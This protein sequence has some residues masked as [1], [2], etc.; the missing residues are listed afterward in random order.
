MSHLHRIKI[1]CEGLELLWRSQPPVMH[2]EHF[3]ASGWGANQHFWLCLLWGRA[4]LGRFISALFCLPEDVTLIQP[5]QREQEFLVC[6][7]D[8]VTGKWFILQDSFSA[9]FLWCVN[10]PPTAGQP[11]P[12]HSLPSLSQ[13]ILSLANGSET[14]RMLSLNI[15]LF[16][17]TSCIQSYFW[18]VLFFLS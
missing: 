13:R 2:T 8:A 7:G 9:W 5:G 4:V 12:A 10:L 17:S 15:L 3:G 16:N 6:P 14:C 18:E 1:R 11:P